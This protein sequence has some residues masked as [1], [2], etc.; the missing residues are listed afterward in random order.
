MTERAAPQT[1]VVIVWERALPV[2]DRIL[3]DARRR[4]VVRDV[5]RVSWS[6]E[7]FRRSLSRLYGTALPPDSVKERECGTG[8][9]VVLVVEDE[10][11]RTVARRS[12]GGWSRVNANL[13][14]AKRRYRRWAAGSYAVHTTLTGAEARKD[15]MLVLGETLGALRERSWDGEVRERRRDLLGEP[16]WSSFAELEAAL[17]ATV[18]CIVSHPEAGGPVT[19]VTDDPWWAIRIVD[20][21]AA[22]GGSDADEPLRRTVVAEIPIGVR[23]VDA[24]A[25]GISL[26]VGAPRSS[27]RPTLADRIATRVGLRR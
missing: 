25:A 15:A 16:T 4:L 18:P 9:F 6:P 19:V 1:H 3:A 24:R 26:P 10:Q 7:R 8:P 17:T 14:A 23:V 21:T 11:P 2:L 13:L 5:V 12:Q 27:I 20:P 22:D